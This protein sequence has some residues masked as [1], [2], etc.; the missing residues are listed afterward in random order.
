MRILRSIRSVN[1]EQGGPIEGIK[2]VSRVHQQ[3]G[4]SVEIVSLDS[5]SDPWVAEC[6]LKVH[7]FGPG[8]GKFGYSPRLVPWLQQ[9]AREYDAVIVNGIWQYNSLGVF[10]ALRHAPTP[11]FVFPHGMLDPWFKHAYPMKHLKKWMYWP[12]GE[13]RVLRGA[14]AVCFTCE[15]E[16]RLAR[17]SFWLYRCN[18]KVVAYGTATPPGNPEEQKRLFLEQYPELRGKRI[19]LFLGRIHP[20]KG[21]DLLIRSLAPLPAGWPKA[22]DIHPPFHLV[23][24]GP[25]QTGWSAELKALARSLGISE[26]ISWTGMLTG[27]LKLGALRSA[28][29]FALPSHQ[30][31]FGIAVAEAL[32]CGVPVLISNKVN[33][34]R[35]VEEDGAGLVENDD[36]AGTQ[37]LF[38]RWCSLPAAEQN[39]CR[40]KARRCFEQ[41]FE[42]C[43][44]AEALLGILSDRQVASNGYRI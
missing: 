6:P 8:R 43:K 14:N 33:I 7:A 34:W 24:A 20:K 39:A 37:R 42:I 36:T 23:I 32:A 28:E 17:K 30:E 21:C 4:H 26:R 11:Y 44:A 15:E 10:R 41:R 22:R 13:Y 9:H 25:D 5:P 12:W 1:P 38:Q 2:Q 40:L 19:V 31:N 29:V 35:E 18:E 16:R 3:A 27:E